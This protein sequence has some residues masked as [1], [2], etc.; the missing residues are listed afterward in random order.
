[1]EHGLDTQAIAV[2]A[3]CIV[4][5]AVVSARAGRFNIT[6]PMAFIAMGALMANGPLA[7]LD[8]EPSSTTVR[9]LVE[10]TLAILLF[11]DASR[12]N[13]RALRGDVALPVRLLAIG[14]PLTIGLGILAATLLYP[15]LDLWLVALIACAVAPTDAALGA[16]VVEDRR[17]PGRIRRA[18]NVE[19]GLN[20]GI[21]TPLV[22]FFIAGAVAEVVTRSDVSPLSAVKELGIGA[23]GGVVIGA[24]GGAMVEWARRHRW[25]SPDFIPIGL[26]ALALLAYAA[27]V[28]AEG[29]GFVAAFV[30]GLTFG[31]ITRR[32]E[33]EA[34]EFIAGA[35]E[36]LSII[37]W[38]VFGAV[39]VPVLGDAT[40][41]DV[42]FALL[43]ITVVRMI[44][45][46]VALVGSG[47]DRRAIAFV[48]WFGPRGLA[49]V[50][51]ALLAFDALTPA[52]GRVVLTAIATTVVL[53]VVA[54]GAS[55][56]PLAGRY[57]AS[58][59]QSSGDS[60]GRSGDVD[61]TSRA[62]VRPR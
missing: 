24:V 47:L 23:L 60:S 21:A 32:T 13:L 50:V 39:L 15:G 27:S 19:S 36:L 18:L 16:P 7:V 37:V 12:L 52:D 11:A 30:G 31:T 5:W 22:T 45:V 56:G 1:M 35:G 8:V 62:F 28:Q 53:S 59:R 38:F 33:T 54:H 43:S 14:L 40:W 9:S 34:V 51:F 55:A 61:V 46:I 26:L 42:A 25:S 2:I 49:S 29:N 10:I 48:G 44:A 3:G 6:A 20:D 57:G 17:V 4:F 41:R 58:V